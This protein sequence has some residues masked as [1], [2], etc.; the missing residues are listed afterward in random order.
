MTRAHPVP[1]PS[2]LALERY[3]LDE[4]V[5][6]EH[7]RLTEHVDGCAACARR[8]G[9]LRAENESFAAAPELARRVDALV[10]SASLPSPRPR[11]WR[12][13]AA[14]AGVLAAA[15]L[16]LVLWP[17]R[18]THDDLDDLDGRP[19][20]ARALRFEVVR[21]SPSGELAWLAPGQPVHPGDAIRFRLLAPTA[22]YVAV[23]GLDAA[24][25]VSVYAPAGATLE[26]LAAGAPTTLDGSIVLDD[27]LGPERLLALLCPTPRPVAEVRAEA[28]RAL[29]AAGGD[30]R[31]V[32]RITPRG[33]SAAAEPALALPGECREATL[34]I[35]K[36]AP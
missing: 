1:H 2:P 12:Y 10:S 26:P 15:A 21:R 33:P 31:A 20:G 29:T 9:E 28:Q 22:G 13:A 27:T 34:L 30:P 17:A 3:L 24:R 23:L 7:A 14:A 11:R 6:A 16:A 35:E 32:E 4:L 19:K 8:L 5:A 25:V 36:V 18:P